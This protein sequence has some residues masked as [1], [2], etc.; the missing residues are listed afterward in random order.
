[1]PVE[2]S[3]NLILMIAALEAEFAD[4][5]TVLRAL[6]AKLQAAEAQSR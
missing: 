4:A 2:E 5:L 3:A 6:E 1:M